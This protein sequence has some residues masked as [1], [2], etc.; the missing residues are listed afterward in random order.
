M[1]GAP[2]EILTVPLNILLPLT[3]ILAPGLLVPIPTF[4]FHRIRTISVGAV[5]V[6]TLR[7]ANTISPFP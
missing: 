1:A 7:L 3:C 5:L 6:V 2:P 4:P